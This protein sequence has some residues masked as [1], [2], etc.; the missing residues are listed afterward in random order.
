MNTIKEKAYTDVQEYI[1]SK[2]WAK[3]KKELDKRM[4]ELTELITGDLL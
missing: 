3:V 4:E 2:K 1:A